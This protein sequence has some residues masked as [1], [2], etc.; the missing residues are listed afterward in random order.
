MAAIKLKV[1][2][3]VRLYRKDSYIDFIGAIG[4]VA[5][6]KTDTLK[7]YGWVNV[8]FGYPNGTHWVSI[9]CLAHA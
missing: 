3:R 9:H 1:G 5:Y 2:D 6:I 4:T 8:D 7:E